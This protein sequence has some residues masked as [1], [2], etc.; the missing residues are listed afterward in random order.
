MAEFVELTGVPR[1]TLKLRLGKLVER[2]LITRHGAGRGVWYG[3]G[4]PLK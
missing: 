1:A 2:N 4:L 3:P